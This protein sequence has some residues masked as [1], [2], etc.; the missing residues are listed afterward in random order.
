M[1][2]TAIVGSLR[3][4]S[5]NKIL[6]QNLERMATQ[7]DF[8]VAKFD[9]VDISLPL[10]NQDLESD[11]PAAVREMKRLIAEADGVIVATP[12][13]NRSFSGVLKNAI[14]WSSRPA[15]DNP[16]RGK[17]VAV[18]G[19][20]T[21]LVGTA[22]AQADLRRVLGFLNAQLLP[23]P[24]LY[25]ASAHE[26]FDENGRAIDSEEQYLSAFIASFLNFA[27]ANKI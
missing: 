7:A 21:G 10:Y 16:W 3:R 1:K 22:L 19:A 8:D 17:P 14:D 5:L 24:E 9:Y 25:L 12:E 20:T 11:L 13:Y 4:E 6:V 27:A 23:T 18:V 2:I 15:G 26:A